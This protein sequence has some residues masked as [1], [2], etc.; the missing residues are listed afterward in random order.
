MSHS[1]HRKSFGRLYGLDDQTNSV[2]ILKDNG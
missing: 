1:I 2:L